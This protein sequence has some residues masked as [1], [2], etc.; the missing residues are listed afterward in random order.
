MKKKFRIALGGLFALVG[1]VFF[2]IPGSMLVLIL[3]LMMLSYDLPKARTALR[4]C[5][6]AMSKSARKLDA[7]L[8]RRKLGN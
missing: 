2:I 3:G 7:Y 4:Y 5:Q 6:N 1:I 8:L